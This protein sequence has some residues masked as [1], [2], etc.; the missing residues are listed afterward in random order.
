LGSVLSTPRL[1]AIACTS[2]QFPAAGVV[3]KK[4]PFLIDVLSAVLGKWRVI[5]AITT[6]AAL[7]PTLWRPATNLL[8]EV[9]PNPFKV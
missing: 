2:T 4:G 3:T 9:Q 1:L 6:Y 5:E 8:T 7:M